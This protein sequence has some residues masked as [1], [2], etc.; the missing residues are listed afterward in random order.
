M[1]IRNIYKYYEVP[2]DNKIFGSTIFPHVCARNGSK[3]STIT[4]I[5][6]DKRMPLWPKKQLCKMICA[7][8]SLGGGSM[9]VLYKSTQFFL[10]KTISH[11]LQIT[12]TYLLCLDKCNHTHHSHS[13]MFTFIVNMSMSSI[14][15]YYHMHPNPGKAITRNQL[16]QAK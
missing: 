7:H 12:M 16:I 11:D 9:I 14:K 10:S 2:L 3:P 1:G 13:W 6:L 8:S 5:E 15:R 4:I